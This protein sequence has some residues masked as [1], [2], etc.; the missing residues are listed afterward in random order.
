M[1]G[2]G[3]ACWEISP[4]L[5]DLG[6]VDQAR[7]VARMAY[8][9]PGFVRSY[10]ETQPLP[11]IF[12]AQTPAGDPSLVPLLSDLAGCLAKVTAERDDWRES[13]RIQ[14]MLARQRTAE[15]HA[16][17]KILAIDARVDLGVEG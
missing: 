6:T 5:Y 12:Q 13:E 7:A 8:Q 11:H 10:L 1:D 15:T 16:A 2:G 3:E 9:N 4:C 14:E 17:R